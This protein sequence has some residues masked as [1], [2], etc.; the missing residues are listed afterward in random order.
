MVNQSI[1]PKL[2]LKKPFYGWVVVGTVFL[3]G[4]SYTGV[5]QSVL[6]V[7]MQPMATEFGWSRSAITGAFTLGTLCGAVLSSITGPVL[8]RHSPRMIA[9]FG[10]MII[11]LGLV[12]LA[13]V[14]QIWQLYLS[15]GI[16]RMIAVGAIS[17]VIP[18]SVSNW[19]EK[20]RG[21]AMGIAQ[22]GTLIG[23]SVLPLL[24]QAVI[25]TFGWRCAWAVIGIVVIGLSAVPSLLFLKRCPEDMGLLPD[26]ELPERL[27]WIDGK[28]DRSQ[29]Q[30][31]E[32]STDEKIWER[33]QVLT[34][35]A[36]WLLSVATSILYFVW[37]GTGLHLFPFL[38]DNGLSPQF[39]VM[40]FSLVSIFA[41]F[42]GLVS[43]FLAERFPVKQLLAVLLIS[44]GVVF[45]SIFKMVESRATIL[46]FT[47]VYGL[48]RGGV[49][50][51]LPLVW[52]DFYGRRSSGTVLGLS[53]PVRS[54]ANAFGPIFAALF[55]D[56]RNSYAIPFVVF[57]LLLVLAGLVTLRVKPP[58]LSAI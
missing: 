58:V 53:A 54:V 1:F 25:L 24:A 43:G 44:L 13:V 39:A 41:A 18:V 50:P 57:S 30:E 28:A 4:I 10:I 21:R 23:I 46:L 29:G 6:S 38:T 33:K 3:I 26:G 49:L 15:F 8:D 20:K 14:S 48:L 51:L 27:K 19:F 40:I 32:I 7:F 11:G 47:L 22:L 56:F 9:F 37:S 52:V 36:F 2:K 5:F 31:C 45:V 35:P 42:G 12:S 17:M 34:T 55:F 16:G